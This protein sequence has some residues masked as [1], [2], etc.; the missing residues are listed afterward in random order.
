MTS[1][2]V[3]QHGVRFGQAKKKLSA[4]QF[5]DAVRV[6]LGGIVALHHRPSTSHQIR[7]HIRRLYL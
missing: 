6:G 2:I 4:A 7:E 3:T 1:T 5:N